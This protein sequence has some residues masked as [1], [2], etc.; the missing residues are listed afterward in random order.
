[1]N[2]IIGYIINSVPYMLLSLPFYIVTRF[3]IL[4]KNK[5]AKNWLREIVLLIFVMYCVGVASQTFI[6]KIEFGNTKL[7][8]V[9]QN[10]FG[11]IN[12]IPG[13]V[14]VDSYYEVI[15]N[16]N[17]L[18]FIVNVIGN[19][20]LFVPIGFLIPTL[21]KNV[22]MKHI[23]IIALSSSL[24]IELLQLPQARGTDIDDLWLNVIG[25]FIGYW[26]YFLLT[27]N[28]K[29]KSFINRAAIS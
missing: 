5:T 26:V 22:S 28:K 19:I 10:V 4:M 9:N 25:A 1:M 2:T 12:L 23:L 6:P 18:Y 16:Y 7:F 8:L 13:K 3:I 24:C 15:Y 20:I 11:E 14:L 29:I 27:K 21:W 17:Y